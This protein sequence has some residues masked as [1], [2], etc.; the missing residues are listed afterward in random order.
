[1]T[2]ASLCIASV[3]FRTIRMATAATAL[4]LL[5]VAGTPAW[6]QDNASAQTLRGK[7]ESNGKGLPSFDIT[8]Y[9]SIA[10][11]GTDG[12]V[13]GSAKTNDTGEF[14]LTYQLPPAQPSDKK[15][16][17]FVIAENGPAMLVTVFGTDPELLSDVVVNERTTVATGVAFARFIDGRKIGGNTYGMINAVKMAANMADPMTGAVGEVLAKKPN[18]SLT[19]TYPKFNSM[20][21]VIAGCVASPESCSKLFKATTPPGGSAPGTVLQALAN[22]TKYPSHNLDDIF[23]LSLAAKAYEP[24]LASRDKPD[25]WL[26]FLKFTGGF[27][28]DQDAGNL[29]NG[30]GSIAIDEKGYAWVND[31]YVPQPVGVDACSG[32]RVMKFYPWGETFPG[33]PYFGGG[34]SGAG[35]G[36]ALDTRGDVWVSNYGFEAPDCADGKVPADPA[37]KVPATHNSVSVFSPDGKPKSPAEG[38]T[39]GKIWWPQGTAGDPQ[40]NMWIGNCGNDSVTFIPNGDPAKAVN[41]PLPGAVAAPPDG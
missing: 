33:S 30:P 11:G 16:I 29:M 28:A 9:V 39:S 4:L 23:A 13:V 40:G 7:V 35:F 12:D 18:G 14:E 20:A 24:V 8:F 21:N 27:Y 15:P 37:K 1:M 41:F 17:L 10:G 5:G 3:F 2:T 22:M 34:L 19:S 25:S 26:L 6:S 38:Y 31:N 36:I 32:L